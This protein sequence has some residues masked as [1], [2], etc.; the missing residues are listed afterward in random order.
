MSGRA[1]AAALARVARASGTPLGRLC[2]P[3]ACVAAVRPGQRHPQLIR[4]LSDRGSRPRPA[5]PDSGEVTPHWRMQGGQRVYDI[6][7]TVM[8]PLVRENGDDS[9]IMDAHTALMEANEAPI[10][11]RSANSALRLLAQQRPAIFEQSLAWLGRHVGHHTT[12]AGSTMAIVGDYVAADYTRDR[13]LRC[14]GWLPDPAMIPET[15][16]AGLYSTGR[17][18]QSELQRAMAAVGCA[19][20]PLLYERMVVGTRS[21]PRIERHISKLLASQQLPTAATLRH[22]MNVACTRDPSQARDLLDKLAIYDEHYDRAVTT[23]LLAGLYHNGLDD[24]VA[25]MHAQ[26]QAA[27]QDCAETWNIAVRSSARAG[28]WTHTAGVLDGLI[29]RGHDVEALTAS[30]LRRAALPSRRAGQRGKN[31]PTALGTAVSTLARCLE[32]GGNVN[33]ETWTEVIKRAQFAERSVGDLATLTCWLIDVYSP[34]SPR[35]LY[36]R[37]GAPQAALDDEHPLRRLLGPNAV[38]ALVSHSFLRTATPWEGIQLVRRWQ[39]MGVHVDE[40]LLTRVIHLR[41]RYLYNESTVLTERN[42]RL[43]VANSVPYEE[44]VRLC[45][46]AW[47]GPLPAARPPTLADVHAVYGVECK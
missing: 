30:E 40:G 37:R 6:Y 1:S 9:A 15:F 32:H 18:R 17:V 46:E 5:G 31:S 35:R 23:G 3:P 25:T 21:L 33:P 47:V 38:R 44:M 24:F 45:N 4:T 36:K 28:N 2:A 22:F 10:D 34:E 13:L 29:Q 43:R 16:W 19:P 12:L 20:G 41:L 8:K 39:S 11:S 7:E 27:G 14:L 26:L 42:H